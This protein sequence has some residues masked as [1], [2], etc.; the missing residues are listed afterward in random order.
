M[1]AGVDWARNSHTG[2]V[3]DA[4]G[5]PVER[6]TVAHSKAGIARLVKI[7]QC[8]RVAGVG[9]ERPDGPLVDAL[10]AAQIVVFVIAPA[11]IKALRSR[12][13]SAGN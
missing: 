8:H 7:L 9:I 2:C 1:F 5:E 10:L 11:Q 13:G 4:E 6:V 12:Y 3:I